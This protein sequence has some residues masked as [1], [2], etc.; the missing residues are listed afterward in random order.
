MADFEGKLNLNV[1]TSEIEVNGKFKLTEEEL[2][3]VA[4]GRPPASIPLIVV[5]TAP[6]LL[7]LYDQTNGQEPS[8]QA[9]GEPVVDNFEYGLE[10]YGPAALSQ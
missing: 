4:G 2:D 6:V 7:K 8:G 3:Q 9:D 10:A 1:E 5:A